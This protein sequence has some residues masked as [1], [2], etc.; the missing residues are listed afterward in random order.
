MTVFSW[1]R[2]DIEN[3]LKDID[4]AGEES[5]CTEQ[6]VI[7]D[8][9]SMLAAMELTEQKQIYAVPRGNLIY[10]TGRNPESL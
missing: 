9:Q 5:C 10:L 1:K 7:E 6:N 8:L 4:M 2:K 3:L